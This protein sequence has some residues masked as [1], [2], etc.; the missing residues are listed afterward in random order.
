MDGESTSVHLAIKSVKQ[1]FLPSAEVIEI[2]ETFRRMVNDCLRIGVE[3]D[4]FT[5]KRLSIL[6]YQKLSLYDIVSYY[7]LCAITHVAGILANRKKSIKR[8]HLPR[9]PYARRPLLVSCYGFKIVG[10]VLKIPLGNRQYRD[11]QLN[12]YVRNVL[13][14]PSSKIRSFT[15]TPDSL[16]VCYSKEVQEVECRDIAG[17]DRN[18]R[19]VTVADSNEV[20]QYDLSKA[21]D[22]AENTRS[23]MRSSSV[24]MLESG[25]ICIESTV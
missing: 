7:K 13:S 17:L 5:M 24:M 12:S 21:V 16:S 10:G 23:I 6:A 14:D 19:N 1:T 9:N 20:M 18:L 25:E 15:L 11:I 2:M 8:G 22:I 4:I 3:N